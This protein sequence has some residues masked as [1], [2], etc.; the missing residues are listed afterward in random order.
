MV[1]TWKNS[2]LDRAYFIG[3]RKVCVKSLYEKERVSGTSNLTAITEAG[4]K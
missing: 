2:Y 3:S 1:Y 4:Y